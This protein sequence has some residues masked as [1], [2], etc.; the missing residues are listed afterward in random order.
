MFSVMLRANNSVKR[1]LGDGVGFAWELDTIL[2]VLMRVLYWFPM[3]IF[4]DNASDG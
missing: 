1:G 4:G 3:R 2:F